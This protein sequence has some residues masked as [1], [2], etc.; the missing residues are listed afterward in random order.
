M[1]APH[2]VT[3]HACGRE[4]GTVTACVYLLVIL[5]RSH[6]LWRFVTWNNGPWAQLG[7]LQMLVDVGGC[8]DID[9]LLW[10]TCGCC[11]PLQSSASLRG[12][13]QQSHRIRQGPN[14][15]QIRTASSGAQRRRMAKF[16]RG[17]LRYTRGLTLTGSAM[18]QTGTNH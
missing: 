7:R 6:C 1:C 10:S 18:K 17:H 4:R 3:Q 15:A 13:T 5:K 16:Y 2:G 9:Y 8:V 11:A 12:Y 14:T